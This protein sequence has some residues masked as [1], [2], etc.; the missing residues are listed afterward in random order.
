MIALWLS[1]SFAQP[2]PVAVVPPGPETHVQ[3]ADPTPASTEE[4]ETD[5]PENDPP[6][7]EAGTDSQAPAAEHV[8]P[9]VEAPVEPVELPNQ[10][11]EVPEEPDA[12]AP[13]PEVHD[14]APDAPDAPD[15]D[16]PAPEP[17]APVHQTP[18]DTTAADE[19]HHLLPLFPAE[20][21]GP[22]VQPETALGTQIKEPPSILDALLPRLPMR[23]F[24][25]G[26]LLLSLSLSFALVAQ[27]ASSL[28]NGLAT[29]GLLVRASSSMEVA[30]RVLS[31]F[32]GLGVLAAWA[33]APIAVAMP[34][35]ALV[36]ALA[37]GWSARDVRP[38]DRG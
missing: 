28:R 29:T 35:V 10:T 7:L 32:F 3:V 20:V 5:D 34:W 19:L 9:P 27:L 37:F 23:G 12:H 38:V 1:L 22:M 36:G 30:G 25:N 17:H 14:P 4:V 16:E 8:E 11:P 33:P 26:L 24:F 13:A 15:T 2:V 21:Q 6:Q 31:V 18:A